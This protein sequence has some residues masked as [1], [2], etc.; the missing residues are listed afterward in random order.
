MVVVSV[1][2]LGVG[3]LAVGAFGICGAACAPEPEL[4]LDPVPEHTLAS[5]HVYTHTNARAHSHSPHLHSQALTSCVLVCMGLHSRVSVRLN[6][7]GR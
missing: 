7:R 6:V 3:G 2:V 1:L 5:T 4:E